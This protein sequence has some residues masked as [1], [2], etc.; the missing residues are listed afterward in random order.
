[1]TPHLVSVIIPAYNCAEYVA[2]TLESVLSQEYAALE[3]IVVNDG[4]KDSTMEVLRSFG[5]RIRVIDQKNAGP[6]AAR[7]AGILAARGEYVAFVDADD[8][9]LPGKVAAQAQHLDANPEVGTVFTGWRVWDPDGEGRFR[10][11]HDLMQTHVGSEVDELNSG[12]LYARLLLNCELLTSTVMLRSSILRRMGGFDLALWNGDDYDFW[13]RASR[14]AR[15]TKLASQG[16]LYRSLPGSV[17]RSPKVTNFGHV[18]VQRAWD[19]WGPSCPGGS[20]VDVAKLK[21][22]LEE[23]ELA[24]AYDHLNLGDPRIAFEVYRR[25]AA[26]HPMQL[27]L[28]LNAARAAVRLARTR[29]SAVG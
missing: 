16:V 9:W 29:I 1:M 19:R 20:T 27:K 26:S 18:V 13:L 22:R 3:V 11:P 23:L 7:N 6:P 25:A 10:R 15:I 2:E 12:W 28:W 14:E 21:L 17:S 5:D 8:I 4:S 24:H